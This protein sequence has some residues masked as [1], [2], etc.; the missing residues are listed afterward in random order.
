MAELPKEKAISLTGGQEHDQ[1]IRTLN[2]TEAQDVLL[3]CSS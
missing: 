1:I 3:A 2:W